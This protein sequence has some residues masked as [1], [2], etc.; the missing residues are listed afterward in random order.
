MA[1]F[2]S[3]SFSEDEAMRQHVFGD[4]AKIRNCFLCGKTL[5][6]PMVVW[7]GAQGL[8]CLHRWCATSFVLRLSRD[9]WE[10]EKYEEE[11]D[12]SG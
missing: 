5:F 4:V 11:I 2:Y 7:H 1:V 8:I 6:Y 10:I 3:D 9:C 12:V